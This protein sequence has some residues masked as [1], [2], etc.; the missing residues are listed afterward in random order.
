MTPAQVLVIILIPNPTIPLFIRDHL[1]KR[2]KHIGLR[3]S[4]KEA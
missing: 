4:T 2:R 1:K 3:E